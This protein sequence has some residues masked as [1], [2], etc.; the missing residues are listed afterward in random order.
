M[1]SGNIG[2]ASFVTALVSVAM[3]QRSSD[4][5]PGERRKRALQ[6]SLTCSEYL[7]RS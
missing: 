6:A 7:A 4:T 2:L 3:L 1:C 5:S